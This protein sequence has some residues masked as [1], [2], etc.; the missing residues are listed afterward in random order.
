MYVWYILRPSD[1]IISLKSFIP[2]FAVSFLDYQLGVV[3]KVTFVVALFNYV[4]G[5]LYMGVL[6]RSLY[7]ERML[8]VL[9]FSCLWHF[10]LLINSTEY[11]VKKPLGSLV[12]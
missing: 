12:V 4:Q 3:S 10:C 7:F 9:T 8:S 2:H 5:V 11:S 1:L 6:V